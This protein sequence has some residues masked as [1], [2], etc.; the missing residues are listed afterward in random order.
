MYIS[1]KLPFI[2]KLNEKSQ[3]FIVSIFILSIGTLIS[4]TI[5][6]LSALVLVGIPGSFTALFL[7]AVVPAIIINLICGLYLIKIVNMSINRLGYKDLN[8]FNK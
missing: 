1:Y 5:F 2:N 4:G 8:R 3:D 6:L 7:V